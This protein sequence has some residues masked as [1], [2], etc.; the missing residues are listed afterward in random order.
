MSAVLRLGAA[1]LVAL[2]LGVPAR[3]A[4]EITEVTSPGGIKAWL[5]EDH[6]IPMITLES[7]FL[8]GAVLDPAGQEGACAL[9]TSLLAE[10][11]G[12]LDSTAFAERREDL[13]TRFGFDCGRDDVAVSLTM[14]SENSAASVDLLRAALVEPDFDPSA[15]ER[16]RAQLV[17]GIE[18][19]AA[20]PASIAGRAF[21]ALA[22]P[23]HPYARPSQGTV[24]SVKALD[25]AAI[26]AAHDAVLARDRLRVA[27]VGDI[28]P[29]ALAPMLDRLFGALPATG[30]DLPPV[31]EPK[32]P[33]GLRVIDFDVPQSQMIFGQHGLP[34]DDPDFV[35]AFVMDYIL[36]G[37]GL[38]SRLSTEVR[39]KRGLTYGIGTMLVPNDF[40]ALYL[41][42]FGTANATAGMAID[43]VRAEWTRMAEGV[44][45][46]ELD[47]AKQFLTG[48]YPLKFSDNARIAQQL[49]GIQ[50][51]GLGIDYVNARNGLVEAVT[52]EDIA[53]VAKRLLDTDELTF[54]VVGRPEGLPAGD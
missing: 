3:A 53:R 31:A 52:R 15:I 14:L 25:R 24:D 17:A 10:G 44:T 22:Y 16:V 34:R 28:T 41:G 50:V 6:S 26:L 51:A 45:Q 36:G 39:E 1:A 13:A 54:V 37:G 43:L 2:G 4:I 20:D 49:L 8:G 30:P 32:L 27:V 23:G 19:D 48:A 42:H 46:E 35:P 5:T 9:M 47:A 40:G 29:E 18:A 33:G 7:S 11:A 21:S 12:G 38:G